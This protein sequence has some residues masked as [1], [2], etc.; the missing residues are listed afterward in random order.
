MKPR[1][2]SNPAPKATT[3]TETSLFPPHIKKLFCLTPL[4]AREPTPQMKQLFASLHSN[5]ESADVDS[6]SRQVP[7]E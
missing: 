5:G 3:L 4:L 1:R 2:S 6:P 7:T